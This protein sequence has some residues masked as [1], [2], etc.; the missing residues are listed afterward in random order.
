MLQPQEGLP[1]LRM[2]FWI[3]WNFAVFVSERRLFCEAIKVND[4]VDDALWGVSVIR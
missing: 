3:V 4:L 1:Q 2:Y